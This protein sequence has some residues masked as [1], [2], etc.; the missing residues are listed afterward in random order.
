[1]PTK[2][3]RIR[4]KRTIRG[5]IPFITGTKSDTENVRNCKNYWV[6]G[7][8]PADC[9]RKAKD[10][11]YPGLARKLRGDLPTYKPTSEKKDVPMVYEG[12]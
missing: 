5:G 12:W 9:E 7:K 4:R 2:R 3:K 11:D 8:V 1:M 10:I 6:K